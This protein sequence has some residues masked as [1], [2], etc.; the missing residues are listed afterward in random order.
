MARPAA[1]HEAPDSSPAT[2]VAAVVGPAA[3]TPRE[4]SP[5]PA[6]AESLVAIATLLHACDL[7]HSAMDGDTTTKPPARTAD[8]PADLGESD[9]F[10][11][12]AK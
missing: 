10:K 12:G 5:K 7:H 11:R 4:T 1:V 9:G 6:G 8:V 2:D 3:K